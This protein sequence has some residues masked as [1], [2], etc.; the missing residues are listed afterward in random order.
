M[1]RVSLT[2]IFIIIICSQFNI[3]VGQTA[4]KRS[5]TQPLFDL[6]LFRANQTI[7][8]PTAETLERGNIEFE[9]AHRFLPQISQ[10]FDY[11]YGLDG[12]VIMRV[13]LSYGIINK[14]MIA[15]AHSNLEDNNDF[16]FRWKFLQIRNKDLPLLAAVQAG[17]GWSTEVY[18]DGTRR[19]KNDSRNIQLYGQ[20][21]LNTLIQKK[22]GIGLVSSYVSN[23]NTDEPVKKHTINLG[24]YIE[25][26]LTKM[27]G[28]MVEIT[29]VVDGF[30]RPYNSASFGFEINT[31]G[32]FFKLI[33]TNSTYINPSQYLAGADAKFK[34][35]E[36]H[37]GFNITRLFQTSK[38]ESTGVDSGS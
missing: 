29:P 37:F 24:G 26:Y 12:Q 35:K 9:I 6:Q 1:R 28:V 31:G 20:L 4:W 11:F 38:P 8:L 19:P 5:E 17:M 23:S 13:G 33:A 10:G 30:K 3:A 22:L 16:R 25:Y 32:H 18:V 27:L 15:A 21:I 34:P 36:W 7:N 14:L 2:T